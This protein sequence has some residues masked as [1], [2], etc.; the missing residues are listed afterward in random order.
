[1]AHIVSYTRRK[2]TYESDILKAITGVL[3]A[4]VKEDS[5]DGYSSY[6]FQGIP[7]CDAESKDSGWKRSEV[8]GFCHRFA[9]G[10]SWDLSAPSMRREGWPS[11]SWTGWK[12]QVSDK[13]DHCS[14]MGY[15][16]SN[17]EI[18]IELEDGKKISLDDFIL[19][20]Q[21]KHL[22]K[23]VTSYIHITGNVMKFRIGQSLKWKPSDQLLAR[24]EIDGKT[25]VSPLKLTRKPN[26]DSDFWERLRTEVFTGIVLYE[27][28]PKANR[29]HLEL[30][31]TYRPMVL[32]VYNT[33]KGSER[34]GL[35]DMIEDL[36]LHEGG[37]T[38]FQLTSQYF[39][40]PTQRQTIRLG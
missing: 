31:A 16:S 36:Y 23:R 14:D 30:L 3:Q 2:L 11:W 24:C 18:R 7:F 27:A 5:S 32:L 10:L 34:I 15:G 28:R 37:E 17:L 40:F 22:E 25:L 12:A 19:S 33:T 9:T 4:W 6:H 26:G 21:R 13:P 38:P 29:E 20:P 35:I 8:R 1:M 39:T